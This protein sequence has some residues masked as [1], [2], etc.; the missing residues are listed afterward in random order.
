MKTPVA[1]VKKKKERRKLVGT[2]FELPPL[3]IKKLEII[4]V[5]LMKQEGIKVYKRR[6]IE[7]LVNKEVSDKE[8]EKYFNK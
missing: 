8:V 1:K 5:Q 3:V 7:W 2:S 6:V 4:R